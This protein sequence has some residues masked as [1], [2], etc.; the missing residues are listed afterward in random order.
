VAHNLDVLGIIMFELK[1]STKDQSFVA[2]GAVC[3][4]YEC[5]LR[6]GHRLKHRDGEFGSISWTDGGAQRLKEEA[7]KAAKEAGAQQAKK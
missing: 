1:N 3:G 4:V 5:Q 2:C 7:E 6:A